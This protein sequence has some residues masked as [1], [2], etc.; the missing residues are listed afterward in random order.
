MRRV[1]GLPDTGQLCFRTLGTVGGR[2]YEFWATSSPGAS[3]VRIFEIQDDGVDTLADR[4][5]PRRH[6]I[7]ADGSCT[8][9]GDSRAF[10]P[11][12]ELLPAPG[13][14]VGLEGSWGADL[15]LTLRSDVAHWLVRDQV[16]VP[17]AVLFRPLPIE[18][19]KIEH[20]AIR[21]DLL[22]S[23]KRPMERTLCGAVGLD[24]WVCVRVPA[25]L[26]G[27]EASWE[28]LLH[29]LIESEAELTANAHRVV[30]VVRPS[31]AI[32]ALW[33]FE[34]RQHVLSYLPLR[35]DAGEGGR[36]GTETRIGLELRLPR[37]GLRFTADAAGGLISLDHR[38]SRGLPMRVAEEQEPLGLLSRRKGD[39]L[40]EWGEGDGGLSGRQPYVL[41]GLSRYLTLEAAPRP[42]GRSNRIVLVPRGVAE[43][44]GRIDVPTEGNNFLSDSLCIFRVSDR[45]CGLV[46]EDVASR[47]YLAS[48]H[49]SI[50][51]L[52][53]NPLSAMTSAEEA[54]QLLRQSWVNRPLVA[55]EHEALSSLYRLLD[56][57]RRNRGACV[58]SLVARLLAQ[59]L[60]ISA[61]DSS[62]FLSRDDACEMGRDGAEHGRRVAGIVVGREA[63][64][65]EDGGRGEGEAR[66]SD[67]KGPPLEDAEAMERDV[68]G[69]IRLK[70]GGWMSPRQLLS[71]PEEERILGWRSGWQRTAREEGGFGGDSCVSGVAQDGKDG[72]SH[73]DSSE[74]EDGCEASEMDPELH[75]A[76][77]I[78]RETP[79][80]RAR[81]GAVNG[82]GGSRS[83][84]SGAPSKH[85][86]LGP[87]LT[88]AGR[89]AHCRAE[90]TIERFLDKHAP[91]KPPVSVPPFPLPMPESRGSASGAEGEREGKGEREYARE[92]TRTLYED[93]RRSW[94][95]HHERQR[96]QLD[97]DAPVSSDG[98]TERT[99]RSK[100][101][102]AAMC[103]ECLGPVTSART[104]L[105]GWLV[106]SLSAASKAGALRQ[107]LEKQ[108]LLEGIGGVWP[109]ASAVDMRR[110][111]VET[112]WL[113]RLDPWMTPDRAETTREGIVAWLEL[114]VMEDR[115][116]RLLDLC[117]T[118]TCA[119]G[120]QDRSSERC[121][122]GK[123]PT[124]HCDGVGDGA[125]GSRGA[126]SAEGV[127]SDV[128]A[129]L[130]RFRGGARRAHPPPAAQG[131][132]AAPE[133]G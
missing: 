32:A 95:V 127:G 107:R 10:L 66:R 99:T 69:Y 57:H 87:H 73:G 63:D 15:P 48:L 3:P 100:D 12:I 76:G 40:D 65:T 86:L 129:V 85:M 121:I 37:Y 118:P 101:A 71:G 51:S 105:E 18:T 41:P 26:S 102:C 92:M 83:S 112:A 8:N 88:V 30:Q 91:L 123:D 53:S 94:T 84:G 13:D 54:A 114:L 133:R 120:L 60:A 131:G 74:M 16:G 1:D 20:V 90:V 113:W 70:R 28:R 79:R 72:A 96:R 108:A 7:L 78:D 81:K 67:G 59:E 116:A 2:W 93:Q 23:K 75:R 115:L 17:A 50:A 49:A 104:K 122:H 68:E 6:Q 52:V 42:S 128:E 46:A 124:G 106:E 31:P 103:E 27:S 126:A 5:E 117:G 21:R 44:G 77:A 110:C 9:V 125:G 97:L 22:P 24:D 29:G 64:M 34:M 39:K 82:V 80:G 43:H 36:S 4:P 45:A 19:S 38:C 11:T 89:E 119:T 14:D 132:R 35:S 62:Q 33:R 109:R 61:R 58:A 47:L 130:A 25:A 55:S 56:E 98:S 111:A